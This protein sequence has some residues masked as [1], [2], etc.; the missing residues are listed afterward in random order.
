MS[1]LWNGLCLG[2]FY[3]HFS[4]FYWYRP[5]P[6]LLL[7]VP[8]SWLSRDT[9]ENTDGTTNR[10]S[11]VCLCSKKVT[12]LR[13]VDFS[14][15]QKTTETT[16]TLLYFRPLR[17][18]LII[19]HECIIRVFWVIL[20]VSVLLGYLKGLLC[21]YFYSYYI[22]LEYIN[23]CSVNWKTLLSKLKPNSSST[24]TERV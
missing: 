23:I 3:I 11:S 19:H 14:P 16:S 13:L 18:S 6:T 22:D 12:E 5:S 21:S 4:W 8:R 1:S 15:Q 24:N 7:E 20:K 2:R 10:A 9:R 17:L